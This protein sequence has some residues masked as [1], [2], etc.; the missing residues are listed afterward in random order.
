MSMIQSPLCPDGPVDLLVELTTADLAAA[1]RAN[2][3]VEVN[4]LLINSSSVSLWRCRRSQLRFFC[5]TTLAGDSAFYASLQTFPWYYQSEKWEYSRASSHLPNTGKLLDVG[6]GTGDF[7]KL[8]AEKGLT[9]SGCELNQ[10][11]AGIGRGRGFSIESKSV[12]EIARRAPAV[13]DVV[14][15]FQVL[16]HVTDPHGFLTALVDLLRPDGLLV[17][18]V[19]Y[20]D[21]WLQHSGN[22]LDWPPHHLTRWAQ[23][24]LMFL[25]TIFP[26]K[27]EN[28]EIEPMQRDHVRSFVESQLS[29]SSVPS[30][31][32]RRGFIHRLLMRAITEGVKRTSALAALPGHTQLAI[33][34]K[35]Q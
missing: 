26:L 32:Q 20:S 23:S 12:E 10:E 25:T 33:F 4:R 24:S 13:F 29:P 16:E 8:A 5:P 27:V 2:L 15:A 22:V 28:M 34:R 9:V 30:G 7:L 18:G 21:G 19:P 17:I 1:W 3:G 6:C 31:I 11:A 14:C 35:R